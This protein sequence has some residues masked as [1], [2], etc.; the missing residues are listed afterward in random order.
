MRVPE[1]ERAAVARAFADAP[2]SPRP[3]GHTSARE[4]IEAALRFFS[5]V[6]PDSLE[7]LDRTVRVEFGAVATGYGYRTDRAWV[8]W[9]QILAAAKRRPRARIA[10]A[11]NA[12]AA[13]AR[14]A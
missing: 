7:E 11:I 8:Q 3:Q 4:V 6:P 9:G 14:G 13:L 10:Y 2:E 12:L 1:F 5:R